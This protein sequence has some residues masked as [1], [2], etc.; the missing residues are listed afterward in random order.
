MY[1]IDQHAAHERV[2]YEQ[3]LAEH[4]T[5]RLVLQSLLEPLL[6]DF[7]PEQAAVVA[8]ELETL[9]HL[10]VEIEPFGGASY[11]VRTLP[12]ILGRENP[13]AALTEIVDGLARRDDL[14][15]ATARG[16][17]GD[18]DLQAR[19]NQGQYADEHGRDAG[20]YTPARRVPLP[21]HLPS[22]PPDDDLPELRRTGAAVRARLGSSVRRDSQ[23]RRLSDL[24][25]RLQPVFWPAKPQTAPA[26]ASIP[27][28]LR[29]AGLYATRLQKICTVWYD[30]DDH[31]KPIPKERNWTHR[32]D[33]TMSSSPAPAGWGVQLRTTFRDDVVVSWP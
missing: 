16:A 26:K 1:L 5:N 20:A 30:T 10:G 24:N 21:A 12:A 19:G 11:L 23:C 15:E 17:A 13:L 14:V 31:P 32:R 29:I 2:L 6:L 28:T 7:S 8:E 25:W 27:D 33:I 9:N 4:E 22:R 18:A 3:M